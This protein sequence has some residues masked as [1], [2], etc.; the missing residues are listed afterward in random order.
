L[1]RQKM[2]PFC[3]LLVLST[4]YAETETVKT[5]VKVKV[6]KDKFKNFSCTFT[7]A[8]D[9]EAVVM[10]DSSVKC[11]PDKPTKKKV[12]N[13][14]FESDTAFYKVSF[15][16]NPEKITKASITAFKEKKTEKCDAGFTRVCSLGEDGSCAE[17]SFKFCPYGGPGAEAERFSCSCVST[18]QVEKD[19]MEEINP[20]GECHGECVCIDGELEPI[21]NKQ[22]P[23]FFGPK[24]MP[25]YCN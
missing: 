20:L 4:V 24:Q 16:I 6:G 21:T 9:G 8:N 14:K 7:M 1:T 2:L 10:G 18:R 17:G 12:N 3:L 15:N 23:T 5:S 11:L 13:F 19:Y 25:S 22:K